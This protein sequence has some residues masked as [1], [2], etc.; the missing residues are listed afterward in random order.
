VLRPAEGRAAKRGLRGSPAICTPRLDPFVPAGARVLQQGKGGGGGG[1]GG[2]NNGVGGGNGGG[3]TGNNG[4]GGGNEGGGGGGTPST[5][6]VSGA[7]PRLV[8]GSARACW[9]ALARVVPAW[10]Q[11]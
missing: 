8:R 3:A 6:I 4:G 5:P 9:W 11:R 10:P 2:G 1:G 7:P